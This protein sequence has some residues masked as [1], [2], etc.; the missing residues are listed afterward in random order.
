MTSRLTESP[1]KPRDGAS[2]GCVNGWVERYIFVISCGTAREE[3]R[4]TA[5]GVETPDIATLTP[6]CE[7]QIT[8]RGAA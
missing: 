3:R 6:G 7:R 8:H 5:E 2:V 1:I 4:L